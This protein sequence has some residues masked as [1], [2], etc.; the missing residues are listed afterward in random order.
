ME[1]L[2]K[3]LK[4][5]N[6]PNIEVCEKAASSLEDIKHELLKYVDLN[7]LKNVI[8]KLMEKLD[9][10]SGKVCYYIA[11][12]LESISSKLPELFTDKIPKLIEKLDDNNPF[13]RISMTNILREV[14]E[15]YPEL[16]T[17]AVPKLLEMIGVPDSESLAATLTL[18]KVTEKYV[19]KIK[20][21][22]DD[23][24]KALE[25]INDRN[26]DGKYIS[27]CITDILYIVWKKYPSLVKKAMEK[28]WKD[29]DENK[30]AAI[31]IVCLLYTSP[32]PRDLSTSRMPSSA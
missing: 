2:E 11:C 20:D 22:V 28:L 16:I 1:K 19:D 14:G 15:K 21:K 26:E 3:I 6:D 29:V 23:L 17:D 7:L 9:D 4:N 13:V 25:L 24:V 18:L 12:T 30:A 27:E 32:S 31:C 5:L 10:K 8:P